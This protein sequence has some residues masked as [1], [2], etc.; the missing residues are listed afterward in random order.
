MCDPSVRAW[1]TGADRGHASPTIPLQGAHRRT[2]IEWTSPTPRTL[3]SV[4]SRVTNNGSDPAD[5]LARIRRRAAPDEDRIARRKGRRTALNPLPSV[6]IFQEQ[7][8]ALRSADIRRG[9]IAEPRSDCSECSSG[10]LSPGAGEPGDVSTT[11]N[12]VRLIPY[13]TF[14]C[15]G[16]W[17]YVLCQQGSCVRCSDVAHVR[18]CPS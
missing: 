3:S 4:R 10:D 8:F 1:P 9:H 13:C 5:D 14:A 16:C 15:T 17:Y 11:M 2:R 18:C 7:F 6:T 12:F